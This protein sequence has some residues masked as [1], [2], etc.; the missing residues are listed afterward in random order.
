MFR[1][2]IATPLFLLLALSS[3]SATITWDGG[4][5]GT[6]W[7]DG[8]NWNGSN[9]AP[10]TGDNAVINTAA[11]ITI[12]SSTA[13]KSLTVSHTSASLIIN[14]SVTLTINNNTGDG[15]TMPNGSITNNGTINIT[16]A[17][18]DGIYMD[19]SS[20][21]A[22]LNNN[23]SINLSNISDMG[24]LMEYSGMT[25]NNSGTLTITAPGDDGLRINRFSTFN[26]LSGG[27]VNVINGTDVG[28]ALDRTGRFNNEGIIN[29]TN[30][31]RHGFE[32]FVRAS[33]AQYARLDNLNGGIM[34][35]NGTQL[36]MGSGNGLR[37]ST[38]GIVN[39]DGL[40]N[41]NNNITDI[42][43]E[44]STLTFT[45][46]SNA[47]FA[48]GASPGALSISGGM[49][50]GAATLNIEIDG[51]TPST[52]YDV[53]SITGAATIS[54]A[55][56]L[57][58]IFGYAAQNG[59][60][61][62][63][64]TAGTVSGAFGIPNISNTGSG[65]VT[66]VNISYPGGNT[67]RVEVS[68]ALPVE[69][70]TFQVLAKDGQAN[71]Y[72]KTASELNNEGFDV[73]RSIDGQTWQS[74]TFVDGNGTTQA[75]QLYTYTD[76]RPLPDLNYYRLK[77]VDFDGKFEYSNIVSVKIN[78]AS[79]I[80]SEFFPNPTSDGITSIELHIEG[81]GIWSYNIVNS[82]GQLLNS[83][84]LFLENGPNKL[85]LDLSGLEPGIY[86]VQFENGAERYHRKLV[87]Y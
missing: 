18:D 32:I 75:E 47:I 85:L 14:N 9:V 50:F 30:C 48:P 31:R 81:A 11:T 58:L 4:G 77:Q 6:T 23:A 71:L 29:I 64:I 80:L 51:T 52:Q 19:N 54:A 73:Q 78:R 76:T 3:F 33:D 74:L 57:N 25:F 46:T 67:V 82:A 84:Q 59:D 42:S 65:N 43:L 66:A 8:N 63:I 86:V 83:K 16:G 55:N 68:T 17:N 87:V 26:N 56:T 39:N 36:S 61:F 2:C 40:M 62:D 28:A 22:T 21:T 38:N 79:M 10:G 12:T 70:I 15:I 20:G 34:N 13:I 49:N 1:K 69:L 72:W 60:F 44:S 45:N 41:I 24:I 35:I 37:V 27:A 5:D 53:V 7:S